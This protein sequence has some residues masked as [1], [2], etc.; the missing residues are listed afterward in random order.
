MT[1][2]KQNFQDGQVLT[3]EQLNHMEDGIANAGGGSGGV[4]FAN[5]QINWDDSTA[6]SDVSAE[7]VYNAFTSGRYVVG[8]GVPIDEN[9]LNLVYDL[10]V[11][12]SYEDAKGVHHRA[13]FSNC[14]IITEGTKISFYPVTIVLEDDTVQFIDGGIHEFV[15]A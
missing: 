15:P 12:E 3:A 9:T 11:A 6:T 1:Y 5:F 4:L 7:Q 14:E 13:T 10:F 2:E 8:R